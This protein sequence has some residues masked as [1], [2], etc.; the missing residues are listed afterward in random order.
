MLFQI[1]FDDIIFGYRLCRLVKFDFL[2]FEAYE[3][4]N[5]NR[6]KLNCNCCVEIK[7]ILTDYFEVYNWSNWIIRYLICFSVGR[8]IDRWRLRGAFKAEP[9]SSSMAATLF[10]RAGLYPSSTTSS[11]SLVGGATPHIHNI[12]SKAGRRGYTPHS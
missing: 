3:I 12:F 1:C 9:T 11:L 10:G 4:R 8:W 2:K 5:L 6:V 7:F